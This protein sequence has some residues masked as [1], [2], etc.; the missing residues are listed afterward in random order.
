[1]PTAVDL[2]TWNS[3]WT[4][5]RIEQ[6]GYRPSLKETLFDFNLGYGISAFL[7]ICFLTMGAFLLHGSSLELPSRGAA[8]AHMV[9]SMYTETIGSW[10]YVIVASAG[11]AIMFGTCI[12]VLDGY[13]R[14][15]C[16]VIELLSPE[17]IA[18]LD[19]R[20]SYLYPVVIWAL[21]GG[22]LAIIVWRGAAI[23]ALVDLATTISFL[24]AP[25]IAVAN[26]RLVHAP[27]VHSDFRPP[28][29]M[30]WLSY[31]GILF[32]AAFSIYFLVT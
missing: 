25:I 1:M 2:S 27:Y 14:A 23:P 4:V 30:R 28:G 32:L 6:T 8:F 21:I 22:T 26:F 19:P 13:A 12:A 17:K 18:K 10:S 29:W 20:H 16:R 11:F 24:I 31:L 7:A 5:E 3:L 9:I 15:L